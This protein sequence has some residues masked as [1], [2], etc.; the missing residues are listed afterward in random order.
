MNCSQ[1]LYG[2]SAY[3]KNLDGSSDSMYRIQDAAD[4]EMLG[5]RPAIS[6]ESGV[7]FCGSFH[8][9]VMNEHYGAAFRGNRIFHV[10]ELTKENVGI[11]P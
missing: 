5:R 7:N 10:L 11:D 8:T 1:V 6:Y 2:E 9:N 4:G 3:G